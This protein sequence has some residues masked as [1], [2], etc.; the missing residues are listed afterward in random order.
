ME[1][2]A[3][4]QAGGG[5]QGGN[6]Q[7]GVKAEVADTSTETETGDDQDLAEVEGGG[8]EAGAMQ[9]DKEQAEAAETRRERFKRE[10]ENQEKSL[11]Q[12]LRRT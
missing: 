8:D 12:W 7:G 3:C 6:V 9:G 11:R 10:D 4:E 2:G 1:G 5:T